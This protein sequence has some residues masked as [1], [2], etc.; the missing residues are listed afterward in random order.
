[1][2]TKRWSSTMSNKYVLAM[3]PYPSGSLHMGH[4]RV[5]AIA[6][7]LARFERMRSPTATVVFPI[8]FDSFGLPAENAAIDRGI[9]PNEWTVKNI[10]AMENQLKMMDTS[11]D[12]NR[13]VSTCEPEYYK[14]TQYLFLKLYEHGLVYRKEAVVNWDPVDQTVLANEQ[15]DLE[16]RAERSGALVE[17]K[18]LEQWFFKITAYQEEL[19]NDLEQLDWPARVKRLQANWIGKTEGY[20]ATCE[21]IGHENEGINVFFTDKNMGTASD[22]IALAHDHPI[23]SSTDIIPCKYLPKVRAT[24]LEIQNSSDS[25]SKKT[26]LGCF[27]GLTC[28]NPVTSESLP[29]YLCG[30]MPIGFGSGA[31]FGSCGAN[32]HL[33][34]FA[35]HHGIPALVRSDTQKSMEVS[36]MYDKKT[37]FKLRDWLVSRQR[38]W[39]TPVPIIHCSN[40]GPVPVPASDLPV[41][42]PLLKGISGRDGSPLAADEEW[43]KCTC[44]KCK[45]PNAK[46]DP[47]TMDTFV[48]SAWYWLRHLDAK[49]DK[50]ICDPALPAKHLPV[51]TYI[52]GIEHAILH[53]LYARF[54]GK[55]LFKSGI[56]PGSPDSSWCG[57]PFKTLLAQGMVTGRTAR[58][59]QSGKYFKPEEVDWTG[60][61]PSNPIIKE[62]GEHAQLS[63]EKMSKSKFNGVDPTEMIQKYGS[64]CTRLYVLFKAAPADELIWD[65]HGIIGMERW[66]SKCRKLVNIATTSPD[67]GG[68][69]SHPADLD[70]EKDTLFVMN[71]TIHEVTTAMTKTYGFHV[72]IS[73]LIKLSNHLDSVPPHIQSSS[74]AF[75]LSVEN[76]AKMVS[77]F[78]PA[79]AKDFHAQLYHHTKKEQPT[80]WPIVSEKDLKQKETTCIIMINGKTKGS[81][82]IP[83]EAISN[84]QQVEQ[85]AL[86]SDVGRQWLVIDPL[87]TTLTKKPEFQKVL[88]MKEGSVI[89]FVTPKTKTILR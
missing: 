31:T 14:W 83:I 39:G 37:H 75:R 79:A 44:P 53:L 66:L 32:L 81:M 68:R 34:Q 35:E 67:G 29:V 11:F 17:K 76:L 9:P 48:D 38:Y 51:T 80:E 4:L 82:K 78:A 87:K 85:Y 8:G 13:Q 58:C 20:E 62:T 25:N 42:L 84:H 70:Q 7:V 27:T 23:I 73:S 69:T 71:S 21:I 61:Y 59:K 36:D 50:L 64:D 19:L 5:Y 28:V 45:N 63:Y 77:P 72:A 10:H 89:N 43:S 18:K 12:W 30:N 40:C 26:L 52:G 74:P 6:D 1:M 88:V 33:S 65:E 86:E 60:M 54:I 47:D 3:F 56:A 22:F 16:G 49:N 57:E 41:K 46:R 15:V 24:A 2:L 55:F